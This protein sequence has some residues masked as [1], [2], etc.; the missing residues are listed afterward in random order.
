MRYGFPYKGSKNQI[1]EK[2][3]N[4]LPEADTFVDLFCGGCAMTH[5]ALLSGKYNNF[6]IND[7]DKRC[8]ELFLNAVHGN[9]PD[10][11]KWISR[12]EFERRKADDGYVAFCWSFGN[13][14]RNYLFGR[15][16]EEYKHALWRAIVNH[17]YE[18][19]KAF[20]FDA[21]GMESETD[22]HKRS[23]WWRQYLKNCDGIVQSGSHFKNNLPQ[24]LEN[25]ESLERLQSL[26]R[27]E[28]LQSLQS[29]SL[30]YR[31]V[32]IPDGGGGLL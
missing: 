26:E 6:I 13:N 15:Q 7:R 8:P 4:I 27:L 21:S 14:G 25:M 20:G 16:I 1:A 12:E 22:I 28:S 23:S 11:D 3:M 10:K 29:Y 2:I 18:P 24:R 30:D 9:I 5:V 31:D 17:D 32:N 19:L